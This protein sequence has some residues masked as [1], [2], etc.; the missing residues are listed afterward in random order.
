MTKEEIRNKLYKKYFGT[1]KDYL[2]TL[3]FDEVDSLSSLGIQSLADQLYKLQE[4]IG[5]DNYDKI[6]N[7]CHN[8]KGILLN[9]GLTDLALEFDKLKHLEDDKM[10]QR[11]KELL[12]LLLS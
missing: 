4:L 12:E 1:V 6:I 9:M 8:I 2:K 5:T 10:K 11:L 3:G 7:T